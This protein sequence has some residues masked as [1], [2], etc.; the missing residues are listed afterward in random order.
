MEPGIFRI[1]NLN[2]SGALICIVNIVAVEDLVLSGIPGWKRLSVLR[3][4]KRGVAR[5]GWVK[6]ACVLLDSV[7][8]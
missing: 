2:Y 1:H 5:I 4:W 6:E 7:L 3:S 8:V